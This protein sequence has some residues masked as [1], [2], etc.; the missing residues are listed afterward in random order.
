MSLVLAPM[1]GPIDLERP[2]Q[3]LMAAIPGKEENKI[4][5]FRR[6]IYPL[7]L[8]ALVVQVDYL[9]AHGGHAHLLVWIQQAIIIP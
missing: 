7:S 2:T 8:S 3:L 5:M 9:R 4:E 1:D 6:A